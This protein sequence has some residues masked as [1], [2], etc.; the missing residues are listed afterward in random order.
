MRARLPLVELER[1]DEL[2]GQVGQLFLHGCPCSHRPRI[3]DIALVGVTERDGA[4]E[5]I[6]L[7]GA[8][9][10]LAADGRVQLAPAPLEDAREVADLTVGDRKCR[11]VVTERERDDCRAL[12]IGRAG[13]AG[14]TARRSA[15]AST[16]MPVTSRFAAWQAETKW[17]IGSR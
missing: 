8:E 17:S 14:A 6:G 5:L 4:L 16:S 15:N 1:G 3:V 12:P 10:E 7:L 11:A 13:E 9:A 2:T